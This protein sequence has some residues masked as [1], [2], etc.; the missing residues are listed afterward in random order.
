[1]NELTPEEKKVILEKGTEVPYSGKYYMETAKGIYRCRQCGNPIFSSEAKYHSDTPGLAGWPSFAEAI[2]GSIE[3]LEDHTF[4]MRRT[5]VVCAKC[6]GHLGHIFPDQDSKTGKHFCVNSCS[7]DL[8][9]EE[10]KKL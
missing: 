5:E 6:K 2:P 3:Y 4:G 9:K 1:M 10:D 8:E 7:L